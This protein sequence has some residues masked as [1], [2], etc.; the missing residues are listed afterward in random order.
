MSNDPPIHILVVDDHAVIREGF[1]TLLNRQADMEIV[2]QAC[3]GSEAVDQFSLYQPD[4]TLMD[5]RMPQMDGL[6]AT[7]AILLAFPAARIIVMSSMGDYQRQSLE[8]GAKAYLCKDAPRQQLLDTIRAV[9]KGLS[10]AVP[11]S[12]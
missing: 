7:E 8:A 5:V 2:A 11:V 12:E 6:L 10:E 9:N 1:T 4:I 3:N